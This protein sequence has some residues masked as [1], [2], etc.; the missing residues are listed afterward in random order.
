[1]LCGNRGK[2]YDK[3]EP[4]KRRKKKRVSVEFSPNYCVVM[5]ENCMTNKSKGERGGGGGGGGGRQGW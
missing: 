5:E 4:R 3:A 2:P 1:M